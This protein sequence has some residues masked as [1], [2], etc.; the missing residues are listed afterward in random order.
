MLYEYKI[1]TNIPRDF[2]P[3]VEGVTLDS[4]VSTCKG[5]IGWSIPLSEIN[6][7]IKIKSNEPIELEYLRNQLNGEFGESGEDV[8]KSINRKTL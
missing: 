2:D 6:T 5:V 7:L 3:E 4:I 1:L 8:V